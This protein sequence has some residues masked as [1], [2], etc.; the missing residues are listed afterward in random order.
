[1]SCFSCC[2]STAGFRFLGILFRARALGLS[3]VQLTGN[4]LEQYVPDPDGVPVFHACETRLGLG[5]LCTPRTAV[6]TRPRS[7]LGRRLPPSS[8][9]SLSPRTCHPSRRAMIT[10]HQR[11]FS[12]I[13]PMPSLPLACSTR[14]ER[15]PLGFTPSFAPSR[16]RPRT[17]GREQARTLAWATSSTS[18]EP[19]PTWPLIT[20]DITSQRSFIASAVCCVVMPDM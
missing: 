9:R 6:S 19:P 10:R 13:H 15:A 12:V 17:S 1:L 18:V 16:Y 2:L 7:V 4:H 20:R 5:A 11:G 14:T 8:G 3:R